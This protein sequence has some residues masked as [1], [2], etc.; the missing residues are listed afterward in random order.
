MPQPQVPFTDEKVQPQQHQEEL[1]GKQQ[2][3]KTGMLPAKRVQKS[4]DRSQ[5]QPGGTAQEQLPP[6]NSGG[7]QENS[8]LSQPPGVLGSS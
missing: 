7:H 8:R 1:S 4:I 5:P 2:I 6:G 3:G